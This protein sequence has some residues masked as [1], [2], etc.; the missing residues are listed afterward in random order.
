MKIRTKAFATI[1]LLWGSFALIASFT[2][3]PENITNFVLLACTYALLSIYLCYRFVLKHILNLSQQMQ[4]LIL[5]PPYNQQLQIK[6]QD[7]ISKIGQK[8]NTILES[9]HTTYRDIDLQVDAKTRQLHKQNIQLKQE[10][11]DRIS[12]ERKMAT[13]KENISTLAHYDPL[14][15]LPNRIFF[16]TILN[17][18]MN[19]AQRHKK[20]LAVLI[21]D[22]DGFSKV[23]EEFGVSGG[24]YVLKEMGSRFASALRS[25]DII[26]RLD[27]D[28][29]IVL[30]ND[31]TKA[32]FASTVAEKLLQSCKEPLIVES[33]E[34]L[35]SAS[36][37][38]CIYPDDGATLESL[39]ENL[40]ISLT[41]AK[42]AGINHYQFYSKTL[43]LEAHEFIDLEKSLKQA[44][45]N[46]ELTL[47][48]Q[49]KLN[50]RRGT[51][52]GVEAL[53]RWMHPQLGFI[54]PLTL[55]SLAED[56]GSILQ[57]GEWS[58]H[59]ACRINKFW[60]DEGYEHLTIAVNISPKQFYH[61]GLPK[62][63]GDILQ[64]TKLNPRYLELEITETTI[65]D[66]TKTAT[67]TLAQ[68]K[69]IGVTISI[70]HFGVGYT[71]ISQL[72]QLPISILKID[73]SFIR[74][75]PHN[76]NDNAITNAF[77]GLAH[78][79]GLEIIAE[80]VESA[81]QVQY[82][83]IQNCDMVQG[84]FLSHPLPAHKITSQFTKLMDEVLV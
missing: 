27:S 22:L 56:T 3:H 81:E 78:N 68:L 6:N 36:V 31:I 82:L 19:H 64:A 84:Y 63:V 55:I 46:N 32:K 45:K 20:I 11:S 43:D 48:Y 38:I 76:P 23:N 4:K 80:G 13:H 2:M 15:S 28:E 72:K 62:L 75:I 40:D 74:G 24:D 49:P 58:L 5:S 14:T 77:I 1:V 51:I 12:L 79:L 42:Q 52:T 70:D 44:I 7:E 54:N 8:I 61:P 26:A 37:G 66:D 34:L 60:Q 47:Y 39:L 69:E 57:I 53:L 9:L 16:N 59:E 83:S 18:A 17:K 67:Q 21:I 73:Q 41:Q 30:L 71:S 33:K 25:E 29:F 10:I 65:M 35:L 50:I